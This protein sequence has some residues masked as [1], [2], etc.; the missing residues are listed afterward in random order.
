M[1]ARARGENAR[2]PLPCSVPSSLV[3]P[4]ICATRRGELTTPAVRYTRY[5]SVSRSGLP[6]RAIFM[7]SFSQEGG[8][9]VHKNQSSNQSYII[10]PP[11]RRPACLKP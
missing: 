9:L 4:F 3:P 1:T 10:L 2:G 8:T 7:N 5:G 11:L 6:R